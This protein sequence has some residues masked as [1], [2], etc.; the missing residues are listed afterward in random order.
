MSSRN[1]GV[2]ITGMSSAVGRR[3]AEKR[4]EELAKKQK[5][6]AQIRPSAQIILDAIAQEKANVTNI[7]RSKIQWTDAN[8]LEAQM[9]ARYMH[10]D[11]LDSLAIR[12]TRL[13]RAEARN[14]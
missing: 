9:L 6:G 14:E 1:D 3:V 5:K 4:E 12:F 8:H 2:L 7:D 13:L 11:F 10:S